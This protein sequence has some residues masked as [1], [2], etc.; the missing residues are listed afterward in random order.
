[1]DTDVKVALIAGG[2]SIIVSF[3]GFISSWIVLRAQYKELERKIQNQFTDKLYSLRLE[4][5]PQAFILTEQIQHRSKPQ[6]I[7]E[8]VELMSIAEKLYVWKT[9]TVSLIISNQSRK[10]FLA[11]RDALS[12]G[13]GEN[14]KYT[15]E[16]VEKIMK[17]RNEFRSSLRQDIGF[18][19]QED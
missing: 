14:D 7:V 4:H 2:I 12:M 17:T 13:Y 9:G 19:Y 6:Q 18:L 11:L 3:L 1:M 16:Q 5:Y 8:Q 10:K 15:N